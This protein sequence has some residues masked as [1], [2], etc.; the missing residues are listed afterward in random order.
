MT[1]EGRY[2]Y[3]AGSWEGQILDQLTVTTGINDTGWLKLPFPFTHG[4]FVFESNAAATDSAAVTV[5]MAWDN[6]GAGLVNT[7]ALGTINAA[8]PVLP[9]I[10]PGNVN[11]PAD[12]SVSFMWGTVPRFIRAQFTG[13]VG[14]FELDIYAAISNG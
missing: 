10:I 2:T 9:I 5:D 1:V 14:S 6:A 12:P 3:P 8:G 4:Y 13:H 7:G 11:G